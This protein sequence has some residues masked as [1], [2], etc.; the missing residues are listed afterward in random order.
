MILSNLWVCYQLIVKEALTN[1]A[2]LS[3]CLRKALFLNRYVQVMLGLY[4][5]YIINII[6]IIS[7]I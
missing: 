5:I 1:S 4:S 2:E 3:A 7:H 6:F